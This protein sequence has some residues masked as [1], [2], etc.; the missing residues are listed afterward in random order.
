MSRNRRSHIPIWQHTLAGEFTCV[1]R[2]LHSGRPASMR[3]RPAAP[4]TGIRFL[5][6][7]VAADQR[8]VTAHWRNVVESELCT[9]IANEHGVTVRTVEHLLA[10]L[11]GSEIDNALVELDGPEVPIMDGS[12]APFVDLLRR[13]GFQRQP[14]VRRALLIRQPIVTS[15]GDRFAM[16]LPYPRARITVEIDFPNPVIGR[17]RRS[18]VLD[19]PAFAREVAAARTF[20]FARDLQAL[21]A[22]GL[23]AGGSLRSAILVDAERV[24][25]EEGLRFPDEFVRHKLLDCV[26]DLSLLGVPVIGHLV[27]YKPGHQLCHQLLRALHASA[28]AASLVALG[29]DDTRSASQHAA[30]TPDA[31]APSQSLYPPLQGEKS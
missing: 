29:A 12:A 7:D 25:N 8:V 6:M 3:L 19:P 24:V 15:A 18:L 20:G 2:G 17:Q 21:H 5:R 23:A 28:D 13:I 16:L 31:P 1:G 14:A 10:A 4:G 22:R 27:A 26:G 30:A 9:T 11:R